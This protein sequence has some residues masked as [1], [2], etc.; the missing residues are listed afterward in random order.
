MADDASDAEVAEA[1][2]IYGVTETVQLNKSEAD[3]KAGL[4]L[5]RMCEA[6]DARAWSRITAPAWQ[7]WR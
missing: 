6:R 1:W 3:K 5:V 2:Q 4:E 7:F